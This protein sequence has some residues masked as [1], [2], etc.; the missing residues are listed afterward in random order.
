MKGLIPAAGLGTRL[1]PLTYTLPKPLLSVTNKP[2]IMYAIEDLRA[3]GITDIGI[4]GLWIAAALTLYTGY[5]YF[6]AGIRHV[7]DEE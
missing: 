5:D 1:R 4:I 3:A 7:V 2:I 6:R